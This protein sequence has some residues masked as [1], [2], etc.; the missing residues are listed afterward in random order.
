MER[1]GFGQRND[2]HGHHVETEESLGNIHEHS[3]SEATILQTDLEGK[4]PK[5]KGSADV[6]GPGSYLKR[7][8]TKKQ[9]MARGDPWE[10]LR[11]CQGQ[12]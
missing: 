10:D 5:T 8:R 11:Q 7:A 3:G 6:D 9:G 12:S 4:D 2:S 1:I